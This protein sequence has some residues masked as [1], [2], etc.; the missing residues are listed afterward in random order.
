[1]AQEGF[2]SGNEVEREE[3]ALMSYGISPNARSALSRS[4]TLK[5]LHSLNALSLCF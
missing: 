1:L 3:N 5:C 2:F 4:L